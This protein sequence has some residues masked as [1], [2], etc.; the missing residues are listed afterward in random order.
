MKISYI[1]YSAPKSQLPTKK[2][3]ILLTVL[4]PAIVAGSMFLPVKPKLSDF[5]GFMMAGLGGMVS[6]EGVKRLSKGRPEDSEN[7][8]T[9]GFSPDFTAHSHRDSR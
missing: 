4:G 7:S 2:S 1:P 5:L 6:I 3:G 8:E 9:N